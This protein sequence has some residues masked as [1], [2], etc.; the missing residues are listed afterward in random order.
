MN[1][2]PND[3]IFNWDQT[4][5]Q[6]VPTGQWTTNRAGEKLI[7]I[8]NSDDR[9]QITAVFAASMTGESSPSGD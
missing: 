7:T 3:L 2:I 5:I 4:A 6:L 8:P 9:R 1:D